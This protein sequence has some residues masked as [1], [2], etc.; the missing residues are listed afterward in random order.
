MKGKNNIKFN[1]GWSF[2]IVNGRL[3][4]IYF[5]KGIGFWAH[6]YVKRNE[7]SKREQ[8]MIDVDIK[9]FIFSYRKGFYYDKIKKV[10]HKVPSRNKIFPDLKN[11]NRKK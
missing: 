1:N 4:E 3:V 11:R 2:A 8:R 7:Y 5:E 6:C 9:K 10:K